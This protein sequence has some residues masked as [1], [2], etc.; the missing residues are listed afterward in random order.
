[1]NISPYCQAV[2]KRRGPKGNEHKPGKQILKLE[3]PV[4]LIAEFGKIPRE[5]FL[6][7]GMVGPVDRV[8]DVAQQ[9]V[10][11]EELGILDAVRS[12]PCD[13]RL[14][15]AARPGQFP[16]SGEAIRHHDATG[17]QVFLDPRGDLD[18]GEPP[19]L[20]QAKAHGTTVLGALD[21]PR[22]RV[23]PG[24]PRPLLPPRRSPPQ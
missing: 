19:D 2:R 20:G 22:N 8:L 15:T 11:P 24:A 14:M 17:G 21:C 18:P 3:P 1:M 9:G 16:E 6:S 10:D 5:M 7:N 13:E 12:A 23:F 4:E